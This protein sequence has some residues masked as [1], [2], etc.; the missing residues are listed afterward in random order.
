[1]NKKNQ[2]CMNSFLCA[3]Q[4]RPDAFAQISGSDEYPCIN[5][6]VRFYQTKK[7]VLVS[8]EIFGLPGCDDNCKGSVHGFHIHSGGYCSGNAEDPFADVKMHYNPC[9][10]EHPYHAGDLPPLFADNGYAFSAF[11]TNRFTVKDIIGRTIIVHS[12]ADDFT[13]QPS[14]NSGKKVAC[15]EIKALCR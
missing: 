5:G 3:M 11:L 4:K 8:V 13:T 2:S 12:D 15:G 1:M 6:M 10:C 9:D 7:G 14:G